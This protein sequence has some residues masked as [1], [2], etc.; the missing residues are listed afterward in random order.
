VDSLGATELASRLRALTSMAISPTAS[1][2]YP[3]ARGLAAHLFESLMRNDAVPE[4]QQASGNNFAETSVALGRASAPDELLSRPVLFL[5]SFIRSG[6]SLLQL[7]LNAH[8][9]L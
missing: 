6:S 9:E 3:T 7:C 8:T 4:G 2:E 1:L 5:L